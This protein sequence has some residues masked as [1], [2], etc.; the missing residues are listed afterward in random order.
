VAD[1]EK[2]DYCTVSGKTPAYLFSLN[3]A[4]RK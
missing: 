4:R 3:K 2:F 1:D